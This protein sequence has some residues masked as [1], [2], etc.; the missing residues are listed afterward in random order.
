MGEVAAVLRNYERCTG[1]VLGQQDLQGKALAEKLIPA[2]YDLKSE[3]PL[4]S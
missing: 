2:D 3:V 1:Q 4:T